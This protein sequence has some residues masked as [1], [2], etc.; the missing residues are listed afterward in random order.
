MISNDTYV[1]NMFTAYI[2]QV[3][4][5][6]TFVSNF[7]IN[8]IHNETFLTEITNNYISQVFQ[9]DTFVSNFITNII[10]NETFL[11]EITNNYVTQVFQN[12]TFVSNFITNIMHNET[13]LTQITNNYITQMFQNDTFVTNFITNII[14]NETFLT[15]ITNNYI[16]QVFQNDTFVTNFIT[17]IIHNE[18]FLTEI[19]NNYIT[20]VFQ[21]DTFVSNFITNIMHNETFLT[22]ITNN[23]ITQIF[24]NDTFVTNFIT[25]IFHN[26]TLL[27][28]IT[29]NFIT[30][31][32]Q[33][34]T[35][36]TETVN[37]FI[38]QIFQNDTFVTNVFNE[39]ITQ[40]FQ[41]DTYV[42]NF[43]TNIIHNETFLT[44]ITNNYIT[45]V[46]QNSTYL[47]EVINTYITNVFQNDTYITNI[48]QEFVT[49]IV[50]NETYITNV[51]NNYITNILQND[52]FI[53][54]IFNEYVTNYLQNDTRINELIE[55]YVNGR[56]VA[57]NEKIDD[58]YVRDGKTN[59][60][61]YGNWTRIQDLY[62]RDNKTNILLNSTYNMCFDTNQTAIRQ[63][64][65][66][67][68][69]Y[70]RDNK[71]NIRLNETIAA[72]AAAGYTTTNESL[73]S[74]AILIGNGGGTIKASRNFIDSNNDLILSLLPSTLSMWGFDNPG[75]QQW[76]PSGLGEYGI[77][78]Q[79]SIPIEVYALKIFIDTSSMNPSY[80]MRLWNQ[81]GGVLIDYAIATISSP[82][83]SWAIGNLNGGPRVLPA[84]NYVLSFTMSGYYQR[85]FSVLEPVT[86]NGIYTSSGVYTSTSGAY[87]T[88]VQSPL[89]IAG[90]DLVWLTIKNLKLTVSDL[91]VS[92]NQ[93]FTDGSG[94][95]PLITSPIPTGNLVR[96]GGNGI[97]L[98]TSIDYTKVPTIPTSIPIGNIPIIGPGNTLVNSGFTNSTL[99]SFTYQ[100]STIAATGVYRSGNLE[101]DDIPKGLNGTNVL[102]KSGLKI[103]SNK[104]IVSMSFDATGASFVQSELNASGYPS[105]SFPFTAGEWGT[106]FSIAEPIFVGALTLYRSSGMRQVNILRL[107]SLNGTLLGTGNATSTSI[108]WITSLPL[109]P[110]GVIL[111]PGTYYVTRSI[112]DEGGG[113]GEG[114]VLLIPIPNGLPYTLTRITYQ[115][116]WVSPTIGAVPS[117]GPQGGATMSI[118]VVYGKYWTNT[119]YPPQSLTQDQHQYAPDATGTYVTTPTQGAVGK[120]MKSTGIGHQIVA[121]TV[122]ADNI[123]T[124]GLPGYRTDS[125]SFTGTPTIITKSTNAFTGV[126][127]VG[128]HFEVAVVAGYYTVVPV[129]APHV[130][131]GSGAGTLTDNYRIYASRSLS[132]VTVLRV[133]PK[134]PDGSPAQVN[135]EMIIH[136]K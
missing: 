125:I 87:P 52:T 70:D 110:G 78:L 105:Q 111:Q 88:S 44:E 120:A 68:D 27:T 91:T 16:T 71:T 108:G 13:F 3:F 45:Q 17:N 63:V 5:N 26:E 21:N 135:V 29:N 60:D 40:I 28:E 14:Q 75:W 114:N 122:D 107:W 124:S 1:T 42:S 84:G 15:E 74:G 51:V 56:F 81:V 10:H 9:N 90:I 126:S 6:D 134:A 62:D 8:I 7:I 106:K 38:T 129:L 30:Q 57:V 115:G 96:S 12:D 4:Q 39:Y 61:L 86:S 102:I 23:Y 36:L 132:S 19:T 72:I 113:T 41:N 89:Y 35:Y 43:I 47:T 25:N 55:S 92:R 127:W 11:T 121:T 116:I 22:E 128:D 64:D 130:D 32:F 98:D 76:G 136:G 80:T 100:L 82:S 117:G 109:S 33:N 85:Y 49:N 95:I 18:T 2:T 34:N 54:N 20:Q 37:N 83:P 79:T 119:V 67:R 53:T 97:L 101:V 93:G 118:D 133:Y 94:K 59:N 112:F 77:L 31:I 24:Q 46:F 73:T 65:Q 123:V 66:I 99:G 58:L 69:L 131:G 103:D 48:F 104:G 50:H